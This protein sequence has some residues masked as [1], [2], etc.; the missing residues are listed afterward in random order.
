MKSS[1]ISAG[2]QLDLPR[3][4][5]QEQGHHRGSRNQT[6]RDNRDDTLYSLF[7]QWTVAQQVKNGWRP[8][9]AQAR[10][11]QAPLSIKP[12]LVPDTSINWPPFLF[13]AAISSPKDSADTKDKKAQVEKRIVP[14]ES[15]SDSSSSEEA[16][17]SVTLRNSSN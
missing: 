17:S 13:P 4:W 2:G 11:G 3:H 15:D 1:L 10:G 9:I 12:F 6:D 16:S 8:L 5:M 14:R 7:L